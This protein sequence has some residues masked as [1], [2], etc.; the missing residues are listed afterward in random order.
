MK[1]ATLKK[2]RLILIFTVIL[3]IS[4]FITEHF[5]GRFVPIVNRNG[6][7][8]GTKTEEYE[9]EIEGVEGKYPIRIEVQEREYTGEEVQALFQ[10]VMEQLDRVILGQNASF[11]RV[12]KDLYLPTQLE[13]FPVDILWE[14]NSYDVLNI[15]GKIVEEDLPKEGILVELRGTISYRENKALYIR[16]VRVYPLTREG[17]AHMLYEIQKELQVRE[18]STRGKESFNLPEEVGGQALSW[19]RDQELHWH[20]VLL[21]G[22]ALSVYLVYRERET[23]R[24]T[25]KRRQEELKRD[26]PGLISKLTML[27]G[28]GTTLRSAWERIVEHYEEQKGQI[29][30]RVVYEEMQVAIYEMRSGISEAEAYE[31][32]GKRCGEISYIKF[33]T[34]L[35]QNL[36]KGSQGL[37]DMLKF[38]A[39]QAFENR[40]SLAKRKGEEAGAKLLMPMMGMLAVVFVMIMAPAFFTLQI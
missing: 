31:R 30:K 12:E 32:F 19:N 24:M 35:S 14:L 15:D 2:V 33:G 40:K 39:I 8:E 4:V 17:V 10:R 5:F 27:L 6:Y 28:T 9:V 1:K 29:G 20:Y 26:Y 21:L 22:M 13:G 7:G 16:N 38:E 36:R 37:S 23:A 3:T 18:E 34:L 11:D 25:E